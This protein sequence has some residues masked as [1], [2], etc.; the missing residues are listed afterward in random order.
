MARRLVDGAL[1]F[2]E[3]MSV[4]RTGVHS[5]PGAVG[6]EHLESG[7]EVVVTPALHGVLR[8]EIAT[9]DPEAARG[10]VR[11]DPFLVLDELFDEGGSGLGGTEIRT[12]Y[13]RAL[14][15]KGTAIR[16]AFPVWGVWVSY[17]S[18]PHLPG[19]QLL[20]DLICGK[21][22]LGVGRASAPER[23]L[24]QSAA[25]VL[26]STDRRAG[27]DPLDHAGHEEQL[28]AAKDIESVGQLLGVERRSD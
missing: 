1:D 25:V 15:S 10:Y 7:G 8:S 21:I 3:G 18:P 4:R 6:T 24:Q 11:G 5:E 19:H 27:A 28:V 13:T 12:R 17:V 20:P 23:T 14:L 22:Q 2:V 9:K 26:R 16:V